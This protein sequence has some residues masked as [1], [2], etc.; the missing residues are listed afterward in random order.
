MPLVKEGK[1]MENKKATIQREE[2]STHLVL[3]VGEK[4][5]KITL[6]DDN[7]NMVKSVFNDLLK[8]LKKG[9]FTFE[10]EDE[11]E[12][13]YHHICSEYLTQLNA[14]MVTVYRELGEFKLIEAPEV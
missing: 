14:E 3:Q 1:F 8:E 11:S 2:D 4:Q 9:A 5:L 10:L 7:P 12:D 13:L 6:T